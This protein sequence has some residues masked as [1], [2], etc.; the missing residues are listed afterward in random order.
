MNRLIEEETSLSAVITT[1]SFSNAF[2]I[3]SYKMLYYLITKQILYALY[4]QLCSL[5]ESQKQAFG[6]HSYKYSIN[7]T[8]LAFSFW[9]TSRKRPLPEND[10]DPNRIELRIQER[11]GFM[12]I[13]GKCNNREFSV[14]LREYRVMQI[15]HDVTPLRSLHRSASTTARASCWRSCAGT[16]RRRW[17]HRTRHSSNIPPTPFSRSWS[18][19]SA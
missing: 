8:I 7:D 3:C 14:D 10:S 1:L 11:D 9:G 19:I 17:S 15:V 12:G 5:P 18:C 6:L 2:L 13:F 4:K 16:S